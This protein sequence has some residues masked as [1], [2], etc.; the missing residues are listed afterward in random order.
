MTVTIPRGKFKDKLE[1][2][3]YVNHMNYKRS[4]SSDTIRKRIVSVFPKGTA[5]TSFSFLDARSRHLEKIDIPPSLSKEWVG[6]AV[7]NLT[8][9]GRLYI[10][11]PI[12]DTGSLTE[13][14]NSPLTLNVHL[15]L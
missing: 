10:L 2:S 4:D 8:G 14:K 3:G 11:S 15:P 1:E 6:E 9:H 5:V 13:G 12:D 7:A